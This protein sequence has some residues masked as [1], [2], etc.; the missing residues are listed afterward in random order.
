MRNILNQC[1]FIGN[2]G[3]DAEVKTLPSGAVVVN[4]NLAVNEPRYNKETKQVEHG[5]V[6]L[7]NFAFYGSRAESASVLLK[8][9]AK[10]MVVSRF[11]PRKYEKDG[12]T[13]YTYEF[14]VEDF[15]LLRPAK[16]GDNGD[17]EV[18]P[19][20]VEEMPVYEDLPF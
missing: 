5:T 15:E 12:V 10:V 11:S 6:W 16:E 20:I 9:G 4:F 17:A 7:N 1:Q 19:E 14:V 13:H 2:L 8:K 18:E 3:R